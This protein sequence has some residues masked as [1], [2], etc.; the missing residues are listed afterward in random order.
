MTLQNTLREIQDQA[1][2]RGWRIQWIPWQPDGKVEVVY[3]TPLTLATGLGGA[4]LFLYSI[5]RVVSHK[6]PPSFILVG[7][8]GLVLAML[9]RFYAAWRQQHGYVEVEAVCEDIEVQK[10]SG[11]GR[12]HQANSWQ[13]R[14]LCLFTLDNKSYRV[15]PTVPIL[16]G[17][18]SEA[19]ALEYL[20]GRMDNQGRCRL[21]V[22]PSNPLHA[23]FDKK[24]R[25]V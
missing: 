12:R 21:H 17:F 3:N 2:D 18:L 10:F 6:A 8:A 25:V 15:T 20:R 11:G 13:V 24:A 4:G 9:G 7:V 14:L 23:V 22:D 5:F 16:S 1:R 19:A